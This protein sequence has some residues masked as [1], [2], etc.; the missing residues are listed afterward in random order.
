MGA[1]IILLIHET[2]AYEQTSY[3]A[4]ILGEIWAG[5][6]HE[7]IVH[8]GT[9]SPPKGDLAILHIDLTRVPEAYLR[10]A[11]SY[12]RVINLA[13]RDISKRIVSRH[14]LRRGDRYDGPVMVKANLNHGGAPEAR[15]ALRGPAHRQ[16]LRRKR[17][18]L[19][20]Y[21][22]AELHDYPVFLSP[23]E[24]P[25]A[26]WWNP[27]LV[28][29]RFLPERE[30]ELYCLRTWMFL[31][32][33]E[34]NSVSFSKVAQVKSHNLVGRRNVPE[35]PNDLRALRHELGFDYGKFDYVL[36]DGKPVLYDA[37]RTP[38]AGGIDPGLI[39]ARLETLAEGLKDFLK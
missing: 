6:G 16:W 13:V 5:Q 12:P 15:A 9:V 18:K 20:W 14:R 28:V 36:R 23:R 38:T 33:A 26:A 30:G 27:D 19:P 11:G 21:F 1:R 17:A 2:D 3:L 31:G 34:T 10:C 24:V 39:R 8:R 25:A 7:M 37:N 32:R 4:K 22:R 35:I 29:E